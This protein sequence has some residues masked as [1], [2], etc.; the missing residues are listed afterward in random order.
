MDRAVSCEKSEVGAE[1]LRLRNA[2]R[3]SF[4][5]PGN[6]LENQAFDPTG[7]YMAGCRGVFK[8]YRRKRA[9]GGIR[10]PRSLV[11]RWLEIR[12]PYRL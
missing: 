8:G 5:R 1:N 12:T 2:P 6:D 10:Q 3:S 4:T 11:N 7:E 9:L